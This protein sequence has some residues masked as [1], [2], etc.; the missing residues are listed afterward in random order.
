MRGVDQNHA[1]DT[2]Y[3][4]V[5]GAN[6]AIATVIT[7]CGGGVTTVGGTYGAPCANDPGNGTNDGGTYGTSANPARTA[8][9]ADY[10][11]QGLG[12]SADFGGNSCLAAWVTRA[13]RGHQPASRHT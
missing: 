2:K 4:N 10:A 9:I 11:G 3:F 1:G 7:N 6:A 12:S 13:F 5:A 8:T